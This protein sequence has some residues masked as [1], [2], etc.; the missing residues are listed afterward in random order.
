[1]PLATRLMPETARTLLGV[2]TFDMSSPAKLLPS[3]TFIATLLASTAASGEPEE[4]ARLSLQQAIARALERNPMVVESALEWRRVQ[5]AADGV[6]GVLAENPVVSTEAGL[7]RDQGW[8]GNQNSLGLRIDQPVD[9]FGQ[10]GTRRQA[11]GDVVVWAK[12]RLA[13]ARAEIAARARLVYVAAQVAS[14]RIA[15]C[16][17]RLAT[18][19][20]TAEALQMRV[21]LGASSDIDLR[22]AEAESGRAEASLQQAQVEESR[23]LLV[24]RDLLELP[25]RAGA[26]P[27]DAF[28][29]PPATLPNEMGQEALLAHHTS[30]QVLEKRRLAIDSEIS[31]L[32]RERLPRLSVGLAAE[33][34]STE[35]R[36]LGIGLSFS[37]ALWR[38]NQGPLVEARVERERADFERAT[39]L[40]GLERRW[41]AL[42]GE[43]SQRL[44]ELTAVE[45]TLQ[46][47]EAVRT[48]VRAGWQA[49]KFDF[50][51]VLLAERSVADT[52]QLRLD[53]WA[54]LWTNVIEM[55]RLLG[56][57]S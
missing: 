56:Q 39:T 35:E 42:R 4:F 15:L 14:T 28:T 21:R 50:L 5:G 8:R 2:R 55:N 19:R 17:E 54:E 6:A 32:E 10:A 30:V 49:G 27:S 26:V 48:L 37:P 45:H 23:A 33:R 13:L 52:K 18:A 7:R 3:L 24:L 36:Y 41:V 25:A 11:A 38:R 53:L 34:P 22:M 43:Q 44:Q 51:R 47:E 12:A 46:N 1:L 57:E 31:R 16:Q 29:P 20:Q 40:A 9:L